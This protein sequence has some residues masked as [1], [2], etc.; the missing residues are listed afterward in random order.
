VL[1]AA[2]RG[3]GA[4]AGSGGALGAAFATPANGLLTTALG[5]A[6]R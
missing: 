2:C 1:Q 5:L 4:R 3:N 6:A